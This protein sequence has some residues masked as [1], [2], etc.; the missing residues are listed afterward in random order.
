MNVRLKQ[1]NSTPTVFIDDQ[2]G[3][4]G[5]G[6]P[7]LRVATRRIYNPGLTRQTNTR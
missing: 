4:G 5:V 2:P 1:H 6:K 3:S 7:N